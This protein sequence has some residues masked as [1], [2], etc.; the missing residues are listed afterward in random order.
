MGPGLGINPLPPPPPPAL[1]LD[2]PFGEDARESGLGDRELIGVDCPDSGVWDC[3][4]PVGE[5]AT[6]PGEF[7]A[8]PVTEGLD[9]DGW[10][11]ARRASML[12]DMALVWKTV[13]PSRKP[14]VRC[15]LAYAR[16]MFEKQ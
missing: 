6:T 9:F 2:A 16:A 12:N 15:E 7:D 3:L 8:G 4:D 14:T 1:P 10:S 11:F 5:S 13:L